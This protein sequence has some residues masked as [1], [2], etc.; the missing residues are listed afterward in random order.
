MSGLVTKVRKELLVPVCSHIG[1]STTRNRH[2][3][4]LLNAPMICPAWHVW[5]VIGLSMTKTKKQT[6][7][8]K[9]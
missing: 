6:H 2:V 1:E 7:G 9:I 3:R 4:L 8:Q 5:L